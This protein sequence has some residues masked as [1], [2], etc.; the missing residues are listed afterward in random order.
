MAL[1]DD[2]GKAM[3]A[4][5][6]ELRDAEDSGRELDEDWDEE[7]RSDEEWQDQDGNYAVDF[8]RMAYADEDMDDRQVYYEE[9]YRA[10][11]KARKAQKQKG[12]CLPRLLIFLEL[13]GIAAVIG[14]W[15]KWLI[16]NL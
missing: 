9:D 16:E 13:A 6:R 14:W 2:P 4:L 7:W 10:E 5:E 1:W 11:K 8:G 15:I 3:R 12:G